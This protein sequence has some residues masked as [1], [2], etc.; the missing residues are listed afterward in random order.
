MFPK[1]PLS[2]CTSFLLTIS[3]SHHIL[4]YS[5][6]LGEYW[7]VSIFSLLRCEQWPVD[8]SVHRI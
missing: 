7:F 3:P 6:P 8:I 4:R 1:C 2:D 5:D